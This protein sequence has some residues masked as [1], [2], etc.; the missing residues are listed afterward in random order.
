MLALA[1]LMVPA[2]GASGWRLTK[3]EHFEVYSQSSDAGARAAVLW[4]EQL[5]AFFIKQTGLGPE[6]VPPVRVIAFESRKEYEPYRLT[7]ADAYFVG[8]EAQDYI[9]MPGLGSSEF[10]VAAHEY[11]HLILHASRLRYPAW[12]KEG[13][14]ELFSTVRVGEEASEL[15]GD[16]PSRSQTLQRRA[17]APLADL[18]STTEEAQQ[19]EDRDRAEMFYAQSWALTGMLFFSPE[20]GPRFRDLVTA[21]SLGEPSQATL[22]KIYRRPMDA[23]ARDL[24][25]WAEHRGGGPIRLPGV[26]AHAVSVRTFEVTEF[27]ARS[28]L[29]DL[30]TASGKLDRA[31]ELYRE[32]G[33]DE[34]ANA[35][36]AAALGTIAL[37]KGDNTG[38]RLQWK[39]AIDYGVRD[40]RLC[41][42]YA[43][44]AGM[45]GLAD[46]EVRP[47][48]ERAIQLKPDFDDA[49]YMLA[50]LEKNAGQYDLAA[51]Q[52]RA[53]RVVAPA[54]AFDYWSI[55]SD[56]LNE[57]GRREEAKAAADQAAQYAADTEQRMHAAQLA[58]MAQTDLAVQFT[59]DASGRAQLVTTR[60]PHESV[61][62]NPFIEVGDDLRRIQG[63]LREIDCSEKMTRFVV[64]AGGKLLRLRVEDPSRVRIRNAPADFVCGPQEKT[65]VTVEYAA[66]Q[67]KGT[68]GVVRGMNF[69]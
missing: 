36:I 56:A 46:D 25:A 41:Y 58:Y 64:E 66:S 43:A 65:E 10:R 17:W 67:S 26:A 35:D 47:A 28:L 33:R 20:Y 13:L 34:P 16:L 54:R 69:R 7:W 55:L 53:M 42:R 38:A 39:R 29:A 6:H 48:L 68:D 49:R 4:F 8:S 45:A 2:W 51:A 60:I 5:R 21:L 32:L 31:E 12:L 9:V 27:A 11:A 62:W 44:L 18:L 22:E 57:L 61:D 3:S 15:G 14:S 19:R 37:R 30:L 50:L 59:R 24:H 52:L 63:A 1:G 23:I 40:A